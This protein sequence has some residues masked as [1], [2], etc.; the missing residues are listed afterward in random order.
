MTSPASSAVSTAPESIAT[1]PSS[2]VRTHG[3]LV[4]GWGGRSPRVLWHTDNLNA[5]SEDT[6]SALNAQG[7]L[8]SPEEFK[9]IFFDTMW[10]APETLIKHGFIY[11]L[12]IVYPEKGYGHNSRGQYEDRLDYGY[13]IGA[14]KKKGSS[15]LSSLYV[16][17]YDYD[18]CS[19]Y[20]MFL[21]G[22]SSLEVQ[23]TG[24]IQT[25]CGSLAKSDI[26][27]IRPMADF[28]ARANA[29]LKAVGGAG[30]L[31]KLASDYENSRGGNLRVAGPTAPVRGR[32]LP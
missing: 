4:Y 7:V 10:V 30:K 31:T 1:R 24:D 23:F 21:Q 8:A 25:Y 12:E 29:G 15:D 13:C 11:K 2:P 16:Q 9:Q 3:A 20:L 26:P 17:E 18:L 19:N 6:C 22:N 27:A 14:W 5:M 32:G 28:V